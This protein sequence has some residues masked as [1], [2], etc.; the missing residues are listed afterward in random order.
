MSTASNLKMRQQYPKHYNI[1]CPQ[2]GDMLSERGI[3]IHVS[4]KH[5]RS[6]LQNVIS[7]MKGK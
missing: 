2:C 6:H 1:K 7:S 4:K 5:V 3:S